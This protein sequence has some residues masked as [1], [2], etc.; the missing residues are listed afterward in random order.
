[1][2]MYQV[3]KK[4]MFFDIFSNNNNNNNDNNNDNININNNNDNKN[5]KNKNNNNMGWSIKKY[6]IKVRKKCTKK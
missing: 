3:Y 1:M 4:K 2:S 5:D 6:S